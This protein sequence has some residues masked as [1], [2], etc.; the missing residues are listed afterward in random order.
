M[1]DTGQPPATRRIAHLVRRLLSG[2][3]GLVLIILFVKGCL[4]DQ[5]NIP[6]D[7]MEPMLYGN[8]RFFHDDRVLV[9]KWWLGPR[10]P[11]THFRPWRWND[12]KRWDVVVFHPPEGTGEA[13]RMIKRVV[14]LPGERIFL[15]NGHAFV[16]GEAIEVP[17]ELSYLYY[18]NNAD[19]LW[20]ARNADSDGER[21]Y[22]T[23]LSKSTDMRYGMLL[24][25]E[26]R[27]MAE[28]QH[29]LLNDEEMAVIK[30]GN[31]DLLG[32]NRYLV[33]PEDSYFV[34]G[35][36]SH[37]SRDSRMFGWVPR[38]HVLGPVIA[39]WW[40]WAHRRDLTGFTYTW[41][42]MLL[43]Y[44]LPAVF[45]GYECYRSA[46]HWRKR[47]AARSDGPTEA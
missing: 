27:L 38:D 12:L 37:A 17:E 40:P 25:E 5:Y 39:V 3:I 28:S 29:R 4:V 14:G 6:S 35:D 42:G 23:N 41:W 16:N 43:V 9:N 21:T 10:L 34:L 20:E 13:T 15:W 26:Y 33:V 22:W 8:G 44:V 24:D 32:D 36:K 1:A 7:S 2:T 11:F 47:A 18:Y 46:R 31:L 45:V 19:F 30:G